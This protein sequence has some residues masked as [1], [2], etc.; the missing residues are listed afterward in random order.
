MACKTKEWEG[1]VWKRV[2]ALG[3]VAEDVAAR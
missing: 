3:R 1:G 2:E